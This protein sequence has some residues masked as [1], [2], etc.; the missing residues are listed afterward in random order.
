VK[1][2][3]NMAT[4]T[5]GTSNLRH[6][7]AELARIDVLIGRE[8][9]RWQLAGQDPTD[10]FRGLHISDADAQMLLRRPFGV[11][12]GQVV[13][14]EAEEAHNYAEAEA[15]AARHAQLLADAAR[16]QGQ[17]ACL[18]QLA[19]TFG[20]DRFELDTLLICLA[21]TLDLRY[22]RLYAYLQ[23][24]VTRK[25]PTVNLVLDLLCAP[26]P[27]DRLPKL[28]RFAGDAPLFKYRL[29]R[30][31]LEPGQ[32]SPPL[33]GQALAVDETIAAWLLGRY[34]C[35]AELALR[36][37]LL[38]P[39][40]REVDGLLAAEIWPTL[41]H[42]LE[43]S[44]TNSAR[45]NPPAL[46][47][48]GPDG[49]SQLAAARLLAGR[50]GRRLLVVNLSELVADGIPALRALRLALRDARLATAIPCLVGWDACLEGHGPHAAQ[51]AAPGPMEGNIPPADLLAEICAH[52]D[53]AIVAGRV[54]WQAEGID[55][56]RIFL[57]L[58]F[59]L[60]AYGQRRA[61]W[62]HFVTD[63]AS[64]SAPQRQTDA[65][66]VGALAG[67]FQLT[68]GQIRDA[69]ASARDRAAQRGD[70]LQDRDLLAAA[71]AHSNPRLS[72]LARKITPR[73]TWTDIVLPEDQ[74]V[75]LREIVA[76]VRGRPLVLD[77]W[78][79]GRKLASSSGVTM[80]FSGPPGTGKTMAAEVIA[81]D[82]SLDLYKI[83]L[84]GIVSKYIG[85]TEKNL[86]RIFG[87]AQ[88]SN[89]VLFFDEA[90]AIFGKRSEVKDAHDRYA[91][92]EISYLLQRMEAYDGVTI[93]ATNLR[94][95]LDEAFTRRLQF[96]VDFPFPEEDYRLRIWQTL[97]PPD[98]PREP[99]L[100]FGLLARRFKLPGGNIRNI[101]VSAA[102]LAAADGGRVAMKHLLHGTRRELQK[103][104]RLVNERDIVPGGDDAR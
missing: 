24:D 7:Q 72:S 41:E 62:Q 48:Y 10:G 87:E 68:S 86:E 61:L 96:A 32:V 52:P 50:L 58:K 103:M 17:P 99:D 75:M 59:P 51:G 14:L 42:A 18:E 12:W 63:L 19:L 22:E 25:R 60:P 98:V 4:P 71:R 93:L 55:R 49:A 39:E 54:G 3:S 20:L 16:R 47:F 40:V 30:F 79:V 80:L 69:V 1:A 102:Y 9:R 95:N 23:D 70:L 35:R 97:F 81:A 26:D 56:E 27:V 46:V 44:Q 65:L 28:S 94:A 78:G 53:L 15:K 45:S 64:G 57:W 83:D 11:S 43:V 31:V 101:I 29:L 67:Q 89:A 84:S 73:F 104:G 76:T 100:D 74:V 5:E 66:N 38:E 2:E 6:L 8:V 36:A 37:T 90:D 77:E 34:Q 92:I 13:G 85:E 21:P 88:S 33:L 82:L 91:N